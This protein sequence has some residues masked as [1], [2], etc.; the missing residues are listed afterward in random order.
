LTRSRK[1]KGSLADTLQC[2]IW[3]KAQTLHRILSKLCVKHCKLQFHHWSKLWSNVVQT[4]YDHSGA[5]PKVLR[6]A[7]LVSEITSKMSPGLCLDKFIESGTWIFNFQ[8]VQTVQSKGKPSVVLCKSKSAVCKPFCT[9]CKPTKLSNSKVFAKY[10]RD[11]SY[12]NVLMTCRIFLVQS[13]EVTFGGQKS[14]HSFVTVFHLGVRPRG[15]FR[16]LKDIKGYDRI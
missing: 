4:W 8:D 12:F 6:Y 11:T 15:H 5:A 10:S 7:V 3:R 13:G 2:N 9:I 16:I 14:L 1:T